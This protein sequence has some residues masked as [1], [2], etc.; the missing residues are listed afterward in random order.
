MSFYDD[1]QSKHQ[2][3]AE[4]LKNAF[5][6]ETGRE[7][8]LVAQNFEEEHRVP[9]EVRDRFLDNIDGLLDSGTDVL[10]A[11]DSSIKED[12][13]LKA[14]EIDDA[15]VSDM[16]SRIVPA[17]DIID[18]HLDSNRDQSPAEEYSEEELIEDIKSGDISPRKLRGELR[19]K[20]EIVWC[21]FAESIDDEWQRSESP[22]LIRDTLG[23]WNEKYHGCSYILEFRYSKTKVAVLRFP[24]VIEAGSDPAFRPSSLGEKTGV[25]KH[26]QTQEP[27][28]PEAVHEPILLTLRTN[29]SCAGISKRIRIRPG[30]G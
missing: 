29:L 7:Y 22:D 25:T 15:D 9:P 11:I 19:G 1:L 18:Y 26:I 16:L 13:L 21:T 3:I 6:R 20:H 12:M 14:A 28:F 30:K 10:G 4:K 24:T 8:Q 27:G 17:Q 23:I 5:N 2:K